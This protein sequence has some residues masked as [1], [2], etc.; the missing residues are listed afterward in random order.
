MTRRWIS[1]GP[2][3]AETDLLQEGDEVVREVLLDDLPVVPLGD[4][5][6]L[7]ARAL[8]GVTMLAAGEVESE[9]GWFGVVAG[10][11]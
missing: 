11:A 10:S 5:V 4:C 7:I 9:C 3:P 6:D 8:G 2:L 1:R